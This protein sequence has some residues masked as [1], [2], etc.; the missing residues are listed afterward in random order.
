MKELWKR[1][2]VFIVLGQFIIRFAQ[3]F[4]FPYLPLFIAELGVDDIKEIAI[5]S[6]I[7]ASANFLGQSVFSPIWGLLADRFGRKIMLIR[8]V[9]SVGFF[10]IIISFVT[11]PWQL[12]IIRFLLG[13]FSGYNAAAIAFIASETPENKTGYALG[14]LQTGQ[15]AGFLVGPA[16]GGILTHFWG[17]RIGFLSAGIIT[18]LICI[19]LLFTR[20][21]FK[22]NEDNGNIKGDIKASF[23]V[24]KMF[25]NPVLLYTLFFVIVITQFA[26]K[27]LE[28]QLATYVSQIHQG[29]NIELMVSGVFMATAISHVVLAPVLGRYGDLHSHYRVLFWCLIGAGFAIFGHIMVKSIG[30]LMLLRFVMGGFLAGILPAANALIGNHASNHHRGVLFGLMASVNALGNFI[31]PIFGGAII[32]LLDIDLGFIV[33]FTIT[34]L[35]F[36]TGALLVNRLIHSNSDIGRNLIN[37]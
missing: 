17:F 37:L 33:V 8:S 34:G 28:P 14:W 35:L 15:Q 11:T 22:A 29:N 25:S 18:L 30:Q 1:N 5:W 26:T 13:C 27:G 10:T 6:G 20:E 16:I 24:I 31:G 2:L 4:V 32:S 12:F 23:N 3:T 21:T 19:P 7:I 36:L 9:I